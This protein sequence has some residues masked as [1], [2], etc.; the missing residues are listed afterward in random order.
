MYHLAALQRE[1]L[2]IWNLAQDEIVH[3]DPYLL[4]PTA[5]GPAL[6]YWDSLIG[7]CGKNGCCLYCGLRGR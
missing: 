1:G 2:K 4:F 5:D 6:V 7:H 3:S